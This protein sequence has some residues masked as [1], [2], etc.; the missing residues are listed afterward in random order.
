MVKNHLKR[1]A[2]PST[3]GILKKTNIFV[4]RPHPGA[5]S[6]DQATSINTLFKEILQKATTTK[7]VKRIL[8]EQE[9]LVDGK[10]IHDEKYNVGFMDVINFTKQKEAY[11]VIFTNKGKLATIPTKETDLKLVKITGEKVIAGG[12]MQI[13][14]ND[15]RNIIIAKNNYSVGD[16]LLINIPSQTIKE[17]LAFKEGAAVIINKGK[18]A[19]VEGTIEKIE[20]NAVNVKTKTT[21]IQTKNKYA[22]IIGDKKPSFKCSL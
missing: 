10:R 11:R 19:G 20:G 15:G 21:T 4:T 2:S 9:V 5:H 13:Q 14:T 18:F 17:H 12:K 6:Y 8:K 22:F 1:I 3:W 16:S 7:E